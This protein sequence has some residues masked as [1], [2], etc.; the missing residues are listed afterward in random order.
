MSSLDEWAAERLDKL[1]A[2]GLRRELR[3]L[4]GVGGK[5]ELNGRMVLNFSSNDYLD[6]ARNPLLKQR[7]KE[8]IDEYGTGATASRLMAGTITL[9]DELE[10]RLAEYKG[11]EA[12]VVFGSGYL[13]NLGAIRTLVG[14]GDAV[15]SDRLN[16]A[17][18]V[19]GILLSGAKMHRYRHCDCSHLESLL[20]E[21]DSQ[22]R[23]V[24]TESVF[25][26]DGD[27]API[28]D[29]IEICERH[30]AILMVD[31]A[32]GTGVLLRDEIQS[33]SIPIA[34]GT[35][36]K[37]LAGAG[38]F[39]AGSRLLCDLLINKARSFIYTTG[40]PP[41]SAASALA[42]L[43]LIQEN[44]EMGRELLRRSEL[45]RSKLQSI[46]FDT[47]N[48]H[49][50]ITPILVGDNKKALAWS[51]ALLDSGIIATAIRPP[52]VPQGTARLRLSV[53]L[54][55]Q[56]DDLARAAEILRSTATKAGI[57]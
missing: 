12:S 57:L 49:S 45:F 9:H 16:H 28:A 53:T 4:P 24:I 32:H 47:L 27:I 55:H 36:S 7:A 17:S 51:R 26:M 39:V 52:T 29:I 25:S 23:L 13:A 19:D 42:A 35:L 41:A 18:I 15:F 48:S 43:D 46:G 37:A 54:A 8:A 56:E 3:V 30:D 50:Q 11:A 31:D 21:C 33:R 5:I 6:L 10:R 22:R 38:G 40:L 20:S 44:P 14:R 34:M 1:S 2:R